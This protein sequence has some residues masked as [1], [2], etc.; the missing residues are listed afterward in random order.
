MMPVREAIRQFDGKLHEVNIDV[1][2]ALQ[3]ILSCALQLLTDII[4][5]YRMSKYGI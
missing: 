1:R 4:L 5:F 2:S 3:L